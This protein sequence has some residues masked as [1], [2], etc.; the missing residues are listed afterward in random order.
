MS[1][2]SEKPESE[3][4]EAGTTESE[5]TVDEVTGRPVTDGDQA[6]VEVTGP[7]AA[8]DAPADPAEKSDN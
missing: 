2:K 7:P 4:T 8:G 1:G 5:V 3:S 6:T